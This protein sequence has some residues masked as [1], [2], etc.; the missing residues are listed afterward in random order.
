[1]TPEF[2]AL[3]NELEGIRLILY[4]AVVLLFV[5]V[6]VFVVRSLAMTTKHVRANAFG[7]E[8][9]HLFEAG[10]YERLVLLAQ[11]QLE[12]RSNTALAHWYL[13]RCYT[14]QGRR[15]DALTEFEKTRLLAPHWSE[16][17][18]DPYVHQLSKVPNSAP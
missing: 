14:L 6:L 13:G 10:E 12:K 3:I 2:G 4:A 18:I 5:W 1:M 16:G 8:A 17:Y 15:D 11:R 9:N 7:T